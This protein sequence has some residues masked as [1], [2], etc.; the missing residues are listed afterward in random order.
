M[1]IGC[2]AAVIGVAIGFGL[3]LALIPVS[4]LKEY[5]E[6]T[7]RNQTV[8]LRVLDSLWR[9]SLPI[10]LGLLG[11]YLPAQVL[12]VIMNKSNLINEVTSIYFYSFTASY[13]LSCIVLIITGRIKIKKK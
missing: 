7:S 1:T 2:E 5:M 9:I 8:G 13:F 6:S 11:F 12:C 3:S 10:L 4:K